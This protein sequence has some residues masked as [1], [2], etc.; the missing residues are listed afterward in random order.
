MNKLSFKQEYK[1]Y[2]NTKL[3]WFVIVH[4]PPVHFVYSILVVH[5]PLAPFTDTD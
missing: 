1:I 3:Y 2:K 4:E 5:T